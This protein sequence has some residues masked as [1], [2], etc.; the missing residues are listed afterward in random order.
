MLRIFLLISIVFS[1][2]AQEFSFKIFTNKDGLQSGD[3]KSIMLSRKGYLWLGS[4]VGFSRFDGQEFISNN[5]INNLPDN[6]IF[7]FYEDSNNNV[8]ISTGNGISCFNGK[9]FRNYLNL[10]TASNTFFNTI[11]TKNHGLL[12]FG[13]NGIYKFSGSDFVHILPELD[14]VRGIT[15]DRKGNLWIGCKKGLYSYD[16]NK[17]TY[18]QLSADPPANNVTCLAFDNA[19]NLWAGTTK[20]ISSISPSGNI[21][22]Y[23]TE[24]AS[25]TIIRDVIFNQ[26]FGMIF[27]TDGGSVIF[28]NNNFTT[29]DLRHLLPAGNL[30]RV[31]VDRNGII[32]IASTAG[33]I[34]MYKNDFRKSKLSET[35]NVPVFGMAYD[36]INK[37]YF[38]STNGLYVNFQEKTEQFS[39]NTNPDDNMLISVSPS[40][41]C[42]LVGNYNGQVYK[43]IN[44]KFIPFGKTDLVIANPVYHISNT[45]PNELWISKAMN[46]VH[47][48]NDEFS[49]HYPARNPESITHCSLRDKKGRIWFANY[50]NLCYWVNGALHI[51]GKKEGFVYSNAATL[52]EDKFGNIWIGTYGYGIIKYDGKQFT[53]F[54]VNHGLVSNFLA[55]SLYDSTENCLWATTT[56]GISKLILNKSGEVSY[57]ENYSTAQGLSNN[58]CNENSIV[59]LKN[60]NILVG[61][62]NGLF[63]YSS[64]FGK[65][66]KA[67]TP[68]LHF[69]G[70]KLFFEDFDFSS[71]SD[72][73]NSMNS[74]PYNLS[75]PYSINHLTF[76]FVGIELSEPEKV[77]YCWKLE[78]VDIAYSPE[79]NKSNCTYPNL[80][81]GTYTFNVV[82]SGANNIWS[83][84]LQYSFTIQAPFY[85]TWWFYSI[86]ILMVCA[87]A[88]LIYY[89]K[90]NSIKRQQHEKFKQFQEVAQAELKAI[91]AQLNPHFMFNILN[92][93]QDVYLDKDEEK[94]QLFLAEFASLIRI[95]LHNSEKKEITLSEEISFIEKYIELEKIRFG[96]KFSY[97][98]CV[99]ESIDIHNSLIPPMLLQPFVENA[100]NHGLLNKKGIGTLTIKISKLNSDTIILITDDGIG[101]KASEI[102]KSRKK[103]CSMAISLIEERFNI[104]NAIGNINKY[105]YEIIDLYE[106]EKPCGTQVKITLINNS[107]HDKLYNN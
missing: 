80:A 38:A 13:V 41:T 97:S 83:K 50:T 19:N 46:I 30:L 8:W 44:K 11:E 101:R 63:E 94:A 74:M 95:L 26:D 32:W 5:T 27:V 37:L 53:Q 62:A 99:D 59:K 71:Y 98:V 54:A 75:L 87:I 39:I 82:V 6:S 64:T 15:C 35:I 107:H 34:K 51:M 47:Y 49:V 33:L 16:G 81:P 43:F 84:P 29:I 55:A 42:M 56:S 22:S 3:L 90:I 93:I 20:G 73:I 105:S 79:T 23:F 45:V 31:A 65:R 104:L 36:R 77:R 7:G 10:K 52:S 70:I 69:K 1:V 58:E 17:L 12:T 4:A 25:S 18:F 89:I 2:S 66:K 78:G 14:N 21:T 92:A 91:R 85:R 28:F 60:G 86:C 40:D 100:I 9:S 96:N 61:T 72:S 102:L 57:I 88:Y 68:I 24:R 48:K 67:Q 76:N 106:D 103:H